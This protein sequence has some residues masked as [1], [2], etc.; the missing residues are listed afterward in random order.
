MLDPVVSSL[1]SGRGLDSVLFLCVS[2]KTVSQ[3]ESARRPPYRKGIMVSTTVRRRRRSVSQSSSSM[4]SRLLL[5]LTA[6][7]SLLLSSSS[8][9][10][11]IFVDGRRLNMAADQSI[12][13]EIELAHAIG[14]YD[15]L[16]TLHASRCMV[17]LSWLMRFGL[18]ARG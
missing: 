17:R 6:S 11:I 1:S 12:V 5:L 3:S 13:T 18:V 10:S 4:G 16:F 2:S 9:S 14:N 15:S 7:W 8:S